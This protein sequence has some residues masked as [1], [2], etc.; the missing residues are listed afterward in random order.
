MEGIKAAGSAVK[1][2]GQHF[3]LQTAVG[4][5][6]RAKEDAWK[7]F[8]SDILEE[9]TRADL[10]G[11]PYDRNDIKHATTEPSST[12]TKDNKIYNES[13]VR[14]IRKQTEDFLKTL[15]DADQRIEA[16]SFFLLRTLNFF[17]ISYDLTSRVIDSA[18]P[19]ICLSIFLLPLRAREYTGLSHV[20]KKI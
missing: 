18:S 6:E 3:M 8:G 5:A 2:G 10:E 4:A 11:T 12:S 7:R 16:V 1:H 15:A 19:W 17:F 9:T 20:R 14:R 13:A